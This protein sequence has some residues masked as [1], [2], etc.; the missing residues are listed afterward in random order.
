MKILYP[1]VC[2]LA[3]FVFGSFYRL[4]IY[5]L[6]HYCKGAA[7][8]A[9]NHTSYY[10]PP[11]IAA[12]WPEEVH[13]LARKSL[14]QYFLFGTFIQHLN[15]YPVGGT[16]QDLSSFKLIGRLLSE[17]KKVVIFP[18]GLRSF[19][20]D[21]TSIKSGIG[22]LALK[23]KCPIIPVYIDGAYEAWNRN[24]FFPKLYGKIT[25]IYGSPIDWRKYAHLDKKEAQALIANDIRQAIKNLKEWKHQGAYGI[26]P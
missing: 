13:F 9:P 3:K 26:P 14:F 21:M 2:S 25:C 17:D 5:G 24:H 8:I 12:S 18:E 20:G 1:A 10:D 23:C 19:S 11:L 15:A 7:I 6:E 4:K 16:A 22:M